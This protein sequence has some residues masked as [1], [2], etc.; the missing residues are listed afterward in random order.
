MNEY[1]FQIKLEGFPQTATLRF[2]NHG[3]IDRYHRSLALLT[4]KHSR[5]IRE[6]IEFTRL[7][8]KRWRYYFQTGEAAEKFDDLKRK[9][10]RQPKSEAAFIMI[11]TIR[12]GNRALPGGLA[13]CRRTWCHHL[14][15]DFLALH[16]RALDQS[17]HVSGVG[18]GIVFGL[19]QLANRL[20]IARLWGEATVSSAPFYEKLA[21][22]PIK[23]LFIIESQEMLAITKRQERMR[24]ATG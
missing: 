2:A 13:Y 22:Q 5:V 19:V 14:T 20:Q 9:I 10:R 11:A 15:L 6:A 1:P 4:R 7:A 21:L 17:S 18:S 23:D 16:P 8:A 24:T 3:E 12:R